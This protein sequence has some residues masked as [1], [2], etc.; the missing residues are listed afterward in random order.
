MLSEA[1]CHYPSLKDNKRILA[2]FEKD[3]LCTL[4]DA[5]RDPRRI[6]WHLI[7]LP[8]YELWTERHVE[9]KMKRAEKA[10]EV[11]TSEASGQKQG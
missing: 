11:R 5:A 7:P 2:E 1:K 3:M 6:E 10:L 4:G 8:D 9:R